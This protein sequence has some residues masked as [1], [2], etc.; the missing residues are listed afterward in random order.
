[1]LQST[2]GTDAVAVTHGQGLTL[3][4][5]SSDRF[6]GAFMRPPLYSVAYERGFGTLYTA[7]HVPRTGSVKYRWPGTAWRL[8]VDRFIERS[9]MVRFAAGKREAERRAGPIAP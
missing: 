3:R 9:H 2:A 6:A 4:N 1:L 8:S 5:E 7:V